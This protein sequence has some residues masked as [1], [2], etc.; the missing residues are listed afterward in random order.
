[1]VQKYLGYGLSIVGIVGLLIYY[2][3]T[4]KETL[5]L[6]IPIAGTI[7][8]VVSFGLVIAGIIVSAKGDGRIGSKKRYIPVKERGKIVEYRKE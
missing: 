1:M 3:P 5:N 2:V 6:D 4:A 7:L 8:M